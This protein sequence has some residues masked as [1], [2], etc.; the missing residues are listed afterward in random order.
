MGLTSR[1]RSYPLMFVTTTLHKLAQYRTFHSSC[2]GGQPMS[3]QSGWRVSVPHRELPVLH[4][5]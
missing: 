4:S 1:L 3:V 5:A 2:I